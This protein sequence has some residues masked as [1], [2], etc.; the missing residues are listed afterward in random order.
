[1]DRIRRD[2][3]VTASPDT[4]PS[5]VEAEKRPQ[6]VLKRSNLPSWAGEN[7]R[8]IQEADDTIAILRTWVEEGI[9]PKPAEL[10][11]EGQ[12]MRA[13]V[14]R[15]KELTVIDH[16]LYCQSKPQLQAVVSKGLR[17]ELFQ[18]MHGVAHVG[19][20]LGRD[21]TYK[22]INKRV[23]WPGYKADI[24]RWVRSCRGCQLTKPGPGRGH[25]LIQERSGGPFERVELDLVGPLPTS[26]SGK[27]YLFLIQD[28]F[29]KWLGWCQREGDRMMNLLPS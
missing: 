13:M 12:E 5:P 18:Q 8:A 3:G 24:A 11:K 19:G 22:R 7:I 29:T 28:C 17:V 16:V 9:R 2:N 20:H 6:R 26:K 14:S 21:R 25:P 27:K 15:W 4:A 1:M 10:D 23:W